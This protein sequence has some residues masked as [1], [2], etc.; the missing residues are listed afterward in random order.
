M[1]YVAPARPQ[2]WG[3]ILS[4]TPP[5]ASPPHATIIEPESW[6]VTLR[7]GESL[8]CVAAVEAGSGP[9]D[10]LLWYLDATFDARNPVTQLEHT[11]S[12]SLLTHGEHRVDLECRGPGGSGRTTR[13]RSVIVQTTTPP[14]PPEPPPTG[15]VTAF[16]T[17][18]G[19]FMR[20]RDDALVD[21]AGES[22]GPW[23]QIEV[24]DL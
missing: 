24:V 18:H 19:K 7:E 14:I 17:A 21:A 22:A 20:V 9:V 2:P 13:V 11:F 4:T 3:V 10:T 15:T 23:E 1:S 16:H 5:D 6:P 12:A 8:R